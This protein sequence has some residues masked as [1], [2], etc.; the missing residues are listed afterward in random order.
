MARLAGTAAHRV[1]RVHVQVRTLIGINGEHIIPTVRKT[2][3]AR[4]SQGLLAAATAGVELP[5]AGDQRR[6]SLGRTK[7]YKPT[8]RF[9]RLNSTGRVP[10]CGVSRLIA[11][12]IFFDE[13]FCLAQLACHSIFPCFLRSKLLTHASA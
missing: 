6:S 2:T 10:T 3:G 11:L 9:R 13:R 1:L 5:H 7:S 12:Y 4:R 8:V